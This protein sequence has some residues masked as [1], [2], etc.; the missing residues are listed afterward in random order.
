MSSWFVFLWCEADEA[1]TR[2]IAM[3][4]SK[5]RAIPAAIQRNFLNY[6][7]E[8]RM[9]PRMMTFWANKKITSVGRAASVRAAMMT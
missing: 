1:N 6:L 5:A 9:M 8:G 3:A 7:N 4:Q 2:I